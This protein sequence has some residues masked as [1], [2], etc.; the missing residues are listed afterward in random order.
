MGRIIHNQPAAARLHCRLMI[1]D[2]TT[3]TR[4]SFFRAIN[5][6]VIRG[7]TP[8][9]KQ[10][11]KTNTQNTTKQNLNYTEINLLNSVY[12]KAL[13]FMSLNIHILL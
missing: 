5:S 8:L 10:T 6:L 2:A 11:N 4:K 3:E 9:R 1:Q 7:R 13:I 12:F